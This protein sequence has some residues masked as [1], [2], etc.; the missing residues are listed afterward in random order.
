MSG[1]GAPDPLTKN[2][3]P[4]DLEDLARQELEKGERLVWAARARPTGI[5]PADWATVSFGAVFTAFSV[6]WV[7]GAAWMTSG[8]GTGHFPAPPG[9][10]ICFPLFGLPFVLVGLGMLSAPYWR[11][12]SLAASWYALTDRRLVISKPGPAGLGFV[13]AA[14]G[15]A[16]GGATVISSIRGDAILKIT[17]VALGDGSGDLI[18]Q[19]GVTA[20]DFEGDP[21]APDSPA[22][23]RT[24]PV[25]E[26]LIGLADVRATERLIRETLGVRC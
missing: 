19:T 1:F 15:S 20:V 13:G 10:Q 21:V 18:L 4:A 23:I 9:M 2:V 6:F 24:A 14:M 17:R 5:G 3:I 22:A 11:R 8:A 25:N 26:G 7:V 12:R 16:V